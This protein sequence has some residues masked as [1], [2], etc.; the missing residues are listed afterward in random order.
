MPRLDILQII[1]EF[2]S[3]NKIAIVYFSLQNMQY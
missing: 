3:T 2:D 1:N